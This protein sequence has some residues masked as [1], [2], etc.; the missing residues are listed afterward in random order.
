MNVMADVFNATRAKVNI[1]TV[2][3]KILEEKAMIPT[4]L[5]LEND[6]CSFIDRISILPSLLLK[7]LPAE[8]VSGII[9]LHYAMFGSGTDKDLENAL[10]S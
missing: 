8:R 10:V 3:E 5:P 1:T 4:V 7:E 2:K 9:N 6:I